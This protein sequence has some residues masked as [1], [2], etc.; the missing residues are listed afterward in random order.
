MEQ[1]TVIII[2]VLIL[3]VII[4]LFFVA[5][6]VAG[7]TTNNQSDED[8]TTDGP[9]YDNGGYYLVIKANALIRIRTNKNIPLGGINSSFE[10]YYSTI[11]ADK[12]YVLT[13]NSS[14]TLYSDHP[15]LITYANG[16]GTIQ[17]NVTT[18][19]YGFNFVRLQSQGFLK[20][21]EVTFSP[22]TKVDIGYVDQFTEN[23]ISD[24]ESV[25]T[26]VYDV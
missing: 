22:N 25:G 9:Y 17:F 19:T 21:G 15:L 4:I 23:F 26:I 18:N 12:E 2:I 24:E 14:T 5:L 11:V 6:V 3:L 10:Q 7:N 13:S 16:K 20:S 1:K 8:I